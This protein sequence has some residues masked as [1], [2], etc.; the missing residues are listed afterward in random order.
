M[1]GKEA[2]AAEIPDEGQA[3]SLIEPAAAEYGRIGGPFDV[4]ADIAPAGAGKD[5]NAGGASMRPSDGLRRPEAGR[6]RL[7]WG[8]TT[9][10]SGAPSATGPCRAGRGFRR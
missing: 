2:T 7:T 8:S 5:T 1:T 6:S 3:G 4:A 9:P 10:S